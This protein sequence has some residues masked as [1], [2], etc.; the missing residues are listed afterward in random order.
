MPP[1]DD[2]CL[3]FVQRSGAVSATEMASRPAVRVTTGVAASMDMDSP[4]GHVK[5]QP[6]SQGAPPGTAGNWPGSRRLNW[7]GTGTRTTLSSRAS[8]SPR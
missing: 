5:T 3:P 4:T 8:A 2:H 6:Q 7:P 1:A